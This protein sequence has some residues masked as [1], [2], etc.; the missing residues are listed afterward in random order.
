MADKEEKHHARFDKHDD[1]VAAQDSLINLDLYEEPD[2]DVDGKE[3]M[4]LQKLN[5]IVSPLGQ[6]MY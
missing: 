4:L 6:W 2:R 5:V 1:F 3:F